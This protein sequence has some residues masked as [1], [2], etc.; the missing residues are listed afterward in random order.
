MTVN[1]RHLDYAIK[2]LSGTA[3]A[4]RAPRK[5]QVNVV[6]TVFSIGYSIQINNRLVKDVLSCEDPGREGAAAAQESI[7]A[8]EAL[9]KTT[10]LEIY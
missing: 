6:L 7:R 3:A 10:S 9:G 1:T 8:A 2:L 5:A 4:K